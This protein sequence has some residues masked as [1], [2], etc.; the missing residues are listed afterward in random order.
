MLQEFENGFFTP[1]TLRMFSTHTMPEKSGNTTISSHFG[2][3]FKLNSGN[4]IH[5]S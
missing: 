1:R 2:F 4:E 5:V 3:A